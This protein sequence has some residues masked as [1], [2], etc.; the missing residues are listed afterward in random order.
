MAEIDFVKLAEYCQQKNI[1]THTVD[2]ERYRETVFVS[3]EDGNALR[4]SMTPH[5]L[6][7]ARQCILVHYWDALAVTI[8][9]S[10]YK[11]EF[12]DSDGCVHGSLDENFRLSVGSGKEGYKTMSLSYT[13]DRLSGDRLYWFRWNHSNPDMEKF[14][15]AWELYLRLKDIKSVSEIKLIAEM[16]MKDDKIFELEQ[17]NE[18]LEFS[19]IL[20]KQEKEQ[21]Q[22]L[23]DEIKEIVENNRGTEN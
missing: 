4:Y 12:I 22:E 15:K 20:L 9:H 7:N 8:W 2:G 10:Y 3:I 19:N 14:S 23:L 17:K 1:E 11:V 6:R 5:L 16:Y 21:Y 13:G 18:D